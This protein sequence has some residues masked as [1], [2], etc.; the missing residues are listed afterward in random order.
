MAETKINGEPELETPPDQHVIKRMLKMVLL[1]LLSFLFPLAV[2]IFMWKNSAALLDTWKKVMIW[3]PM[4]LE[5]VKN[6]K[7][8]EMVWNSKM[9]KIWKEAVEWQRR[10]GF[11]SVTT[12]R[13][14]LKS[15]NVS[16]KG[17]N[18]LPVPVVS[19]GPDTPEG[20]TTKIKKLLAENGQ[21]E[22][23]ELSI[24][25]GSSNEN[26]TEEEHYEDFLRAVL[27]SS[28]PKYRVAAN[29]LRGAI[30]GSK[31]YIPSTILLALLGGHFSPIIHAWEIPAIDGQKSG[32]YMCALFDVNHAYGLCILPVRKL[33]SAVRTFDLMNGDS[34]GLII[35]K[36]ND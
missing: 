2:V 22:R 11:C 18:K 10:E 3:K 8:Q 32:E 33:Y 17:D 30:F 5:I 21:E 36:L 35:T 13:C 19:S 26:A 6:K 4:E 27:L 31:D 16:L 20:F 12:Q 1:S 28:N 15:F 9:G 24:V 14:L 25:R 7:D 29:F 34:R 23:L